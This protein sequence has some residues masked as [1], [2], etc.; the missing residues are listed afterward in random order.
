MW[1]HE[2]FC[3]L[4][5]RPFP[6]QQ[7]ETTSIFRVDSHNPRSISLP[8]SV[9]VSPRVVS[10]FQPR[11]TTLYRAGPEVPI[12]NKSGLTTYSVDCPTTRPVP[13]HNESYNT[14]IHEWSLLLGSVVDCLYALRCIVLVCRRV[15]LWLSQG[16]SNPSVAS[17]W[18]T[19]IHLVCG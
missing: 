18:R 3:R 8:A 1:V 7:S 19:W 12:G 13:P 6:T 15:P 16:A 9:F 2:V 5:P 14:A 4:G 11:F 17:I 10:V